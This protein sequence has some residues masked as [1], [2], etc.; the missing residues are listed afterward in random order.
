MHKLVVNVDLAA[1]VCRV[2]KQGTGINQNSRAWY[3]YRLWADKR[4]VLLSLRTFLTSKKIDIYFY[5]PFLL[6]VFYFPSHY[7]YIK[8]LYATLRSASVEKKNQKRRDMY[9]CMYKMYALAV[10]IDR[11]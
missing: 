10:G 11:K 5:F 1:D 2:T 8:I 6:L 3:R 9:I 7:I 4:V